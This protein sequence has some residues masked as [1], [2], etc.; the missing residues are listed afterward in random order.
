[1]I[2]FQKTTTPSAIL[3]S[4][5]FV[6]LLSQPNA[7]AQPPIPEK[8]PFYPQAGMIHEDLFIF[9]YFDVGGTTDY[10]CTNFVIPGHRGVD[11]ELPSFAEQLVGVP[12]FAAFDGTVAFAR[13]GQPDMNTPITGV[14]GQANQVIL[15]HPGNRST[16]YLHMKNGSV[17]VSNG[18]TVVQGQQIGLVGSSGLSTAPHLHFAYQPDN[19]SRV[20][21]AIFA[22]PCQTA[23][24]SLWEVQ[25]AFPSGPILNDFAIMDQ[26]FDETAWLGFPYSFERGGNFVQGSGREVSLFYLYTNFPDSASVRFRF[27]RPNGTLQLEDTL[28]VSGGTEL[29]GWSQLQFTQAQLTFSLD[30]LELGDWTCEMAVNGTTLLIA[31]FE[32]VATAPERVNRAP[33]PIGAEFL[34]ADSTPGQVFVAH[35]THAN[36]LL[37][38]PDYDVM[39]YNYVWKVNGVTVR[40]ITSAAL[41]DA[42]RKDLAV[43]GDELCCTIT[44]SDGTLSAPAAATACTTV[45]AVTSAQH[46]LPYH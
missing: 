40:D 24:E 30:L 21:T 46:W 31:P 44:A 42:L 29:R 14:L 1:M 7:F 9:N 35:V 43:D 34:N 2:S 6:T 36:R 39:R 33:N 26:D 18:Q 10:N 37:D 27:K 22:G 5:A 19:I 38:D 4:V 28:V 32:V 23:V 16:L 13:D 25:P 11:T 45:L 17:A 41:T 12:I 8:M 20:N 3:V 15:N